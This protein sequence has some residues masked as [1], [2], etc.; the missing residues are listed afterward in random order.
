MRL[1]V[2]EMFVLD[3]H[4]DTTLQ[5]DRLRDL[6]I[7]NDHS[8]FDFPKMRA[9][10]VDGAFFALYTSNSLTN[11][12]ARLQ[13]D[14]LLDGVFATLEANEDIAALALSPSKALE[15]Q[16][17]GLLS[18]FLG[19]ENGSPIC[20]SLNLL[21][22]YYR[23]G[24]RYMTL[25]H[26]GNN[27]IC[28]SC[29]TSEKRWHGLSPFGR[30][31][32]K[33]M[34]RLGMIIDVSHISDESFYDVIE[35]SSVPVVATH[36]CCRA[37]AN[38]PRNMSDEMLK[39]LASAGGVIQI[40]FYPVFLDSDFAATLDESGICDWGDKV[41]DEFKKNP[42]NPVLRK[43][44]YDVLDKLNS[45]KRPSFR[46]IVDHIDYA[47]KLIGIDHVGLGSDFDGIA[48][49]PS[50]M[51]DVSKFNLIFDEMRSR[52]YSESDISKVA[53]GNF[54]RVFDEIIRYSR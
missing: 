33:E 2:K 41:E 22:D 35:V 4:F 8:Q 26:A 11:E 19:M 14:R 32:V 52:G 24:V 43:N 7:D 28:D 17:N 40:N 54:L 29:A 1:C 16:K 3:S 38:H 46:K 42:A 27:D 48:V 37:L 5:I 36:S 49:T 45:L 39:T 21:R 13:A 9:G 30:E 10:G 50:G 12:E 25:T 51:E 6:R 20:G 34:N 15:N 31:V 18:I 23:R 44:W 47:V 53:G